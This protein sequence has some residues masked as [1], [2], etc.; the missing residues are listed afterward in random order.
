MTVDNQVLSLSIPRVSHQR[1]K[2]RN[3]ARGSASVT[4]RHLVLSWYADFPIY[5]YILVTDLATKYPCLAV[6]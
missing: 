5:A 1:K 2:T 4:I 6:G 3:I